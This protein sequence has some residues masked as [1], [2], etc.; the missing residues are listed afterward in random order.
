MEDFKPMVKM[1]V[2]SANKARSLLAYCD[3]IAHIISGKLRSHD[4]EGL[5]Q[6]VGLPKYDVTP[7][8]KLVSA[9]KTIRVHDVFGK[10]YRITVEEVK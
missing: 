7:D 6:I 10:E 5:L 9:T 2:E 4:S 8:G 1:A 3:Y